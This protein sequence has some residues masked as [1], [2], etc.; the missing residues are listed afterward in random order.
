MKGLILSGGTGSRLRPLTYTGAKQLIPICNKPI[1][2]YAV[3]SLVESDRIERS[4]S[5]EQR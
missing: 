4:E 3:E 1:L 5:A 2:Y